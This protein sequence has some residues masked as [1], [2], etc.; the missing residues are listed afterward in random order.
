MPTVLAA[1]APT[2]SAGIQ[3]VTAVAQSALGIISGNELL[4]ALFCVS[5]VGVASVSFQEL[6]V[7]LSKDS[8]RLP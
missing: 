6:R 1:E 5:L 2:I 7:L 4:M 3:Q 8:A